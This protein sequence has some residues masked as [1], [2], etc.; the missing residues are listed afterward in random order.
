MNALDG[1]SRWLSGRHAVVLGLGEEIAAL[2]DAGAARPASDRMWLWTLAAYEVARTIAEA[3]GCFAEG[4]HRRVVALKADL[5]RVRVPA[6][7]LERV[8]YDRREPAVAVKDRDADGWDEARRDLRVGDPEDSVS[9][10]WLIA[11]YREVMGAI[12]AGDVLRRHG[13]PGS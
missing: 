5:E 3:V 10:R 9:A 11:R 13:D 1:F 2:M 6:A 12:A 4:F 8:R 7:K